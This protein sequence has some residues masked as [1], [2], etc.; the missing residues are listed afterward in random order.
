MVTKR[1]KPLKKAQD[2]YQ[3]TEKG[4]IVKARKQRKYR[5]SDKETLREKT[6]EKRRYLR[7]VILQL[8][9]KKCCKCGFEDSR[10]LQIDH[11]NG[12]GRKD[13]SSKGSLTYYYRVLKSIK[14]HELKYQLLC[15][16]CNWIKRYENKEYTYHE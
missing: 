15:A 13:R 10:A 1:S 7:A 11:V 14:R 4:K 3:R 12:N 9:G 16:N 2:K 8:L 5:L 6:I